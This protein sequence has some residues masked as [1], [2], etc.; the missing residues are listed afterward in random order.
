MFHN[1]LT[2]YALLLAGYRRML[3]EMG[4]DFSGLERAGETL[5]PVMDLWALPEWALLRGETIYSR[6][7]LPPAVVARNSSVELVNASTSGVL[8]VVLFIRCIA[9][10]DMQVQTDSGIAIAANPVVSRGVANDTRFPQLGETSQATITS[11][12]VAAGASLPQELL[13]STIA[14]THPYIIRP[15]SKLFIV[16]TTVNVAMSCNLMWTERPLLP[17]ERNP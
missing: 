12:D 4:A 14:S 5:Q 15:G 17:N 16:A 2:N 7:V 11:G 6:S 9:G 1:Q 3:G 10:S 8:V 13:T